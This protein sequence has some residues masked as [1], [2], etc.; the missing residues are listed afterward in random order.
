MTDKENRREDA[1]ASREDAGVSRK[2]DPILA[3]RGTGRAVWANETADDYV[4]RLREGW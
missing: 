3:L 2:D 1:G 4:R